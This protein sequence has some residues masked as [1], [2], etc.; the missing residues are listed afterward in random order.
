VIELPI[1]L[2]DPAETL[3]LTSPN[4]PKSVWLAAFGQLVRLY[5]LDFVHIP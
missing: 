3:V 4:A 1:N 5:L 2:S